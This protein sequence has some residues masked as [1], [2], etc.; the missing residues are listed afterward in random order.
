MT[1]KCV[2]RV[3]KVPW[4]KMKTEARLAL[5]NIRTHSIRATIAN[6]CNHSIRKSA[7]SSHREKYSIALQVVTFWSRTRLIHS[8]ITRVQPI[9]IACLGVD[10]RIIITPIHSSPTKIDLSASPIG[11][12]LREVSQPLDCTSRMS[13]GFPLLQVVFKALASNIRAR[14]VAM[15]CLVNEAG[16]LKSYRAKMTLRRWRVSTIK[17]M[18]TLL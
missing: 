6:L 16:R 10:A 3:V 13:Q 8:T 12:R 7:S 4:L 14:E 2:Q 1:W 15:L 17:T 9:S 18:Q 5:L 11:R